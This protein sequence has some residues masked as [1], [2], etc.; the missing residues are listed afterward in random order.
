ML[1]IPEIVQLQN[2]RYLN[3]NLAHL[4][5]LF[6]LMSIKKPVLQFKKWLHLCQLINIM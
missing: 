1:I 4:V 5:I 3:V 6:C 2:G